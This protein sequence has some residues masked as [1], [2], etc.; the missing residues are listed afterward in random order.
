MRRKR[1]FIAR[2]Q[3]GAGRL[4]GFLICNPAA[5]GKRWVLEVYRHRPDAVR[6]TVPFLMHQAMQVLAAEG[7]DEASLC[8]IPG[9]NCAEPL[10]GDSP[11]VRRSMVWGTRYFSFI[12]DAA[13]LY[14]FKSRFRPQF[15]NRYVCVFPRVTLGSAW[16]FVRLVSVLKLDARKSL[17]IALDR[18]R[19]LAQRSKLADGRAAVE[20]AA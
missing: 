12:F 14:H 4:E 19:K 10:R 9:L 17:R 11:L 2:A 20:A 5:D 16:A 1:I 3:A 13:G 8:L 6:G 7:V 18:L 15:E